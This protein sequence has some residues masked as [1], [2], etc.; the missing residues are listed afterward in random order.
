MGNLIYAIVSVKHNQSA[1]STALTKIE[2]IG[3]ANPYAIFDHDHAAVFHHLATTDSIANTAEALIYAN[4]IEILSRQFTLLPVRFGSV[5]NS[6]V[7]I[8]QM[9]ERNRLV[10]QENL[11][12]VENREEFGL[13]IFCDPATIKE[14]IQG[15]SNHPTQTPLVESNGTE[16]SKYRQWV[17][18]KLEEHREEEARLQYLDSV[19]TEFKAMVEPMRVLMKVKKMVTATLVADVV[20]LI[21]KSKK[22]ELIE[23]VEILQN[24]HPFLQLVM[25]GP[26]P[27]Y[28]FVEFK[29][30]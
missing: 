2:G 16:I 10:I 24:Q 11:A 3:G 5:L 28:S 23:S 4:V 21:D 30:D 8:E 15:K 20:M 18:K 26:W 14:A 29:Q 27:P 22:K 25:T 6:A 7:E 1:L 12:K 9:L 13:K 17:S 19:I